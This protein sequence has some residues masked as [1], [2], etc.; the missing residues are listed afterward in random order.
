MHAQ[1]ATIVCEKDP[2]NYELCVKFGHTCP[3]NSVCENHNNEWF[4][5]VCEEGFVKRGKV[6]LLTL[7][8]KQKMR[9]LDFYQNLILIF[10]K[11][12]QEKKHGRGVRLQRTFRS[13]SFLARISLLKIFCQI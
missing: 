8:A 12:E 3:D 6:G 5:C 2:D 4:E 1:E 11:G 13:E 9:Q 7:F 10:M